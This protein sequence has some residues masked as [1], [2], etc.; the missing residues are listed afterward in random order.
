MHTKL[1]LLIRLS[2]SHI[3]QQG[4]IHWWRSRKMLMPV[5]LHEGFRNTRRGIKASGSERVVTERQRFREPEPRPAGPSSRSP[6]RPNLSRNR[7]GFR[8][9][10]SHNV[11][12]ASRTDTEIQKRWIYFLLCSPFSPLKSCFSHLVSPPAAFVLKSRQSVPC[13]RD[14][15][16]HKHT[17]QILF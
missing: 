13:C 11:H 5:K 4:F 17:Q 3:I 1:Q 14:D 9:A 15:A 10:T 6:R 2:T 7:V 16:R 12:P 8:T